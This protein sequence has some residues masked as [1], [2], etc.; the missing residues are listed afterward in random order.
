MGETHPQIKQTIEFL[1]DTDVG[2]MVIG[3]VAKVEEQSC[4]H[5]HK[6]RPT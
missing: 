5:M 1:G 3:F 4:S 2:F 6:Q